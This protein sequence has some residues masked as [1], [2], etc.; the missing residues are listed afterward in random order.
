[1]HL[2]IST[3]E[4]AAAGLALWTPCE[5][6][7]IEKPVSQTAF[8]K[9]S[10]GSIELGEDLN[11]VS[12]FDGR[13]Q[14]RRYFLTLFE[15]RFL[16]SIYLVRDSQC[17]RFAQNIFALFKQSYKISRTIT[18]CLS[19]KIDNPLEILCKTGRSLN[20]YRSRSCSR[21]CSRSSSRSARRAIT[22]SSR[23]TSTPFCSTVLV[24]TYSRF[25]T[26]RGGSKG[27]P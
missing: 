9:Q 22:Y 10:P 25:S 3:I 15:Y 6:V 14:V 23:L 19:R 1:M 8:R 27:K 21:S 24:S 20:S 5:Y 13:C 16:H 17:R 7:V 11:S 2:G 4:S 12:F 18:L 26:S